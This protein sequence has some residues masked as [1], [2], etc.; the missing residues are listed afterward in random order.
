MRSHSVTIDVMHEGFIIFAGKTLKASM[1]PQVDKTWASGGSSIFDDLS[2]SYFA[3]NFALTK[4]KSSCHLCLSV[5]SIKVTFPI[6]GWW[7][8]ASGLNRNK[9][10]LR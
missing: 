8:S 2:P 10:N 6:R 1:G 9:L 5:S 7:Q 4:K 3:R